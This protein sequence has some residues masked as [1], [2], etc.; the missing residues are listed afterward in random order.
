MT[1]RTGDLADRDETAGFHRSLPMKRMGAGALIRDLD[2]NV[3][4]VKPSY[5]DGWELPGGAVEDDESPAD[6]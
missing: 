6:A 5:K 4:M 1:E 2:G 3:L